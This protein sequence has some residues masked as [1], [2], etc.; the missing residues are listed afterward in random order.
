MD[1][2]I[3]AKREKNITVEGSKVSSWGRFRG[4]P[5]RQKWFQFAPKKCRKTSRG[6][7]R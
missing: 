1:E 3:Y 5:S 4:R 6:F 2:D 7:N